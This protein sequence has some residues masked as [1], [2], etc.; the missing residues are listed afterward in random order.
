LSSPPIAIV[1]IVLI[2]S[3][4]RPSRRRVFM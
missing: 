3:C 4:C 1:A 2:L